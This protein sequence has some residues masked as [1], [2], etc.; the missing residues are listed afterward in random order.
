MSKPHR[1]SSI[2]ELPSRGRGECPVC[3]RRNVKIL[4][5]QDA[6]EQKFKICKVCRAAV[7]HGTKSLPGVSAKPA[8][9]A[10]E[11]AK[12]PVE[13]EAAAEPAAAEETAAATE[14]AVE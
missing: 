11:P 2:R 13:T 5:E 8:A 9:P 1:G 3:K 14:E 4:F 6:G 10:A 12:A 7:K